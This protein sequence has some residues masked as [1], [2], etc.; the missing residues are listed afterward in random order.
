MRLR[1][2]ALLTVFSTVIIG[3]ATPSKPP[4]APEPV[5]P[6]STPAPSREETAKAASRPQYQ[7]KSL[8]ATGYA[9]INVQNHKQP[10]QQRLM[11]IRAAKADAYR[12]LAEQVF[13]LALDST[14]TVADLAITNDR[15][16]ARVEGT[17]FGAVLSSITPVNNDTYEVTLTL[18]GAV[19]NDIRALY[20]ESQGG[21]LSR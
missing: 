1:N 21:K 20:V 14:T 5:R 12:N 8:S 7:P 4:P 13:G 19:V 9:V 11:A 15:F 17:I 6:A 2:L 18:D 10:A 16:R 3:C